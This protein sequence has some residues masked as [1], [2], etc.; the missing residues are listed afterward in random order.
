MNCGATAFMA[1]DPSAVRVTMSV[2]YRDDSGGEASASDEWSNTSLT[3]SILANR[4]AVQRY[5]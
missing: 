3:A 4:L 1:N 5:K 2:E